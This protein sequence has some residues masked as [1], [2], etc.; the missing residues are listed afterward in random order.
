MRFCSLGS[1]SSGNSYVVQD[2]DTT[3][4][5]DCGFGLNET[6]MRLDLYGIK[7]EE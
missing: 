3:L 4:L 5:V 6:V 2:N 1:G 7:P